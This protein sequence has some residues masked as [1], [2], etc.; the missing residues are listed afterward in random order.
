MSAF[1]KPGF[2]QHM[3]E[4]KPQTLKALMKSLKGKDVPKGAKIKAVTITLEI[5]PGMIETYSYTNMET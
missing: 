4:D 5:G 3:L 2:R 1:R